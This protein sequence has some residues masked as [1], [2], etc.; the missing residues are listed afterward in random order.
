M[1]SV[2]PIDREIWEFTYFRHLYPI[3][4]QIGP[5]LG[6]KIFASGQKIEADTIMIGF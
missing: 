3:L 2:R 5:F 6:P 4:A 1:S